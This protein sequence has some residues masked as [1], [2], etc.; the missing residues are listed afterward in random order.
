MRKK[1]IFTAAAVVAACTV[2]SACAVSGSAPSSAKQKP[3][4]AVSIV[5]EAAFAEAV[6]GDCADVVTIVPPGSS[7]ETYEPT[8]RQME[9]FSSAQVYFAIG[10]PA[11]DASILPKIPSGMTVVRLQDSVAA[12][13]PDLQFESGGRDPHI[14][15]SPKRVKVMVRKIAEEMS[16]ADPANKDVYAA[17]AAAYEARMDAL[18]AQVRSV[19][20][21]VK[22]RVFLVFHPAFGYF[23]DD[24]G[25]KMVALEQEGKESTAQHMQELVDLARAQ[26]A[27]A[28]F[29]Q[30]ETDSKQAR[31]FAEE[32][33]GQTVQLEPLSGDY[34]SNL[35]KMASVIA[36]EIQTEKG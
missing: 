32:I 23:A 28:I 29:Y 11:E 24:Y 18:D 13:Y 16:A 17:N 15:L 4:V 19:L 22:D 3:T 12:E 9:E 31:A 2:L 33:G 10:V 35:K 14:W 20:S 36:G 25:L 27:K 5:P 34:E 30:A 7:P 26:G 8:P 6:C 1:M 21:P